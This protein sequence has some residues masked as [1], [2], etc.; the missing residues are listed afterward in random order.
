MKNLQEYRAI[1][2]A[3]LDALDDGEKTRR[4]LIDAAIGSFALSDGELGDKSTNGRL[5]TLRARCGALI[6][7]M[8]KRKTIKLNALSKYERCADKPVAIRTERCEEAILTL[9]DGAPMTKQELR[10]E[11]VKLFATDK[12]ATARDDNS[13]VSITSQ[14]LKRLTAEGTL[15]YDGSKYAISP[16]E[17]ASIKDRRKILSLK[18]DFLFKVHSMGGEFFEHYFM[19]LLS[20]YLARGG[21]TVTESTVTGGAEDGGIDGI[22]RTT[23]TLGFRET[24]M[25]PTKNRND[26]TNETDVRGFWG[27]VCAAGGSRGIYATTSDF[28]PMAKKLLESIDNCVGINGDKIFAMAVDVGY[29]IKRDGEKLIL[30]RSRFE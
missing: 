10:E 1:Y 30:D 27:A 25:V 3:I 21:K 11:M 14:L 24:I 20:R 15:S 7:E 5:N 8:T 28:H 4:E 13:L 29:G 6:N 17:Y 22:L 19:N 23:D 16:E 26:F 2:R 12:T 9:L 18:A